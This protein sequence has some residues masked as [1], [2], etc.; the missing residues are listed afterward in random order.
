MMIGRSAPAALAVVVG[1]LTAVNTASAGQ[2]HAA[3]TSRVL[4]ARTPRTAASP[5]RARQAAVAPAAPARPAAPRPAAPA[6]AGPGEVKSLR[7]LGTTASRFVAP[8]R[9]VDALKRSMSRR[10]IQRDLGTLMTAA[11]LS[12]IQDEVRQILAEGRVQQTTL[13]V[14]TQLEWMARRRGGRPD[15][16]R[17]LRW[18]GARALDGF[19]FTVDDL[20]Q[21]YT[22]FVPMACG[23]LSLVRREP[24][25][26]AARRAEAA[27]A[28]AA[29]VEAARVEAERAETARAEAARQEAARAEA[30]RAEA[31][32]VEAAR[33][34]AARAEAARQ[35]AA[36]AEEARRAE[37]ARVEA[38]RVAAEKRDLRV[39]PFVTGLLGKRK[40][41]PEEAGECGRCFDAG[42]SVGASL[43]ITDHIAFA[44]AVGFAAKI[45]DGVRAGL[46][47]D[48]PVNYIFS[49]GAYVGPGL[50]FWDLTRSANRT[51][52]WMVD[53][54]VPVWKNDA[55][56]HQLL[57]LFE[58]R[59]M[60]EKKHDPADV[61]R[62]GWIG[63]K[64]LFK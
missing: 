20:N 32:R 23:N 12:S 54:G 52:G 5:A 57:A 61:F 22:F 25:R 36:R 41:L 40:G 16:S 60:L 34:E 15:L 56:H 2:A 33:Q 53:A 18:D 17:N 28:E 63:L 1:F 7:R 62:Q 27:R 47:I 4:D 21:T 59:Q 6:Q 48:A 29:R 58:W 35:E 50:T 26:E 49:N 64:Y 31:A 39:R 42:Y 3:G 30:V 55:K 19:E 10:S 44:P 11:G 43:G 38:A 14:G 13:A 37:A 9:T 45:Q 24:S 8:V 46:V 51:P